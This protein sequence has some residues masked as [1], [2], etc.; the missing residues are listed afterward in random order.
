MSA[1]RV[2][3]AQGTPTQIHVSSSI[4][5]YK[6]KGNLLLNSFSGVDSS[7]SMLNVSMTES[8]LFSLPRTPEIGMCL[9]N[10]QRQHRTLQIQTDVLPYASCL[11]H[12][13]CVT[14]KSLQPSIHCALHPF[15]DSD[16]SGSRVLIRLGQGFTQGY[17]T[18]PP[19]SR[20]Y[21][22]C[23]SR[24]V[25]CCL[26]RPRDTCKWVRQTHAWREK[27]S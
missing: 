14:A 12:T 3:H 26:S 17:R 5:A 20:N 1:G 21:L 27:A 10:N 19:T 2:E 11:P 22:C 23:T 9:P 15:S 7:P 24:L 18:H 25:T 16:W 8:W 6:K 13:P 4:Q